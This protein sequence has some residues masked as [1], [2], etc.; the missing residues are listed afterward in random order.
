MLIEKI[1][2]YSV[3]M[4]ELIDYLKRRGYD[5]VYF[6]SKMDLSLQ[7]IIIFEYLLQM[8]D[9]VMIVAP[10]VMGVR[11]YINRT[12]DEKD[13]IHVEPT[14]ETYKTSNEHYVKLICKAFEHLQNTSF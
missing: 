1:K 13:I 7:Y 5:P 11:Q 14:P 3:V 10:N 6:F 9:I 4:P 8:H 12:T 2:D